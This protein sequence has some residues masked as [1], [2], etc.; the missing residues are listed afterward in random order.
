LLRTAVLAHLSG[1][2][3]DAVTGAT[4]GQAM[5]EQL[6]HANLFLVPLDGERG[7]YR[8]HHLFAEVLRQR[9]RQTE[10]ALVPE[11]HRRA[12]AWFAERGLDAEAIQHALAAE[13]WQRAAQL[14]EQ[15]T[16]APS[17]RSSFN[18]QLH[19]MR[20]WLEALPET[21]VRARPVLCIAHAIA[22]MFT[23][24]L[25]GAEARLLDAERG[26][27]PDTPSEEAR[28]LL[29]WVAMNRASIARFSGDLA[30]CVEYARQAL[31]SQPAGPVGIR[32]P[33]LVNAAHAYLVTGDVTAVTERE[34]AAVV[35]PARES[36]NIFAI[37]RGLTTLAR[38]QVLRGRL[39]QAEA[40]YAE[41]AQVAPGSGAM[42]ALV[43]APAY[44]IGL[45]DL[46][47][48]RNDLDAAEEHLAR[49][50]ALVSGALT[51]DAE[52]AT[53]GHIAL[54]RLLQARGEADRALA[55]LDAFAHLG[56]ERRFHAPLLARGAAARAR[57]DLARGDQAAALRWAEECGLHPTDAPD[58]PREFEHLT[59]ARVLIAAGHEGSAAHARDADG[60]LR[61]L[62]R[63]L[64]AAEACERLGSV[65]EICTLRAL[66][67]RT[68]GDRGAA[69]AHIERSLQLASPEG[70]VRVFADEGAPL[71]ELLGAWHADRR[72]SPAPGLRDY[73]AGL[74][75]AFAVPVRGSLTP[76]PRGD[77]A[78]LPEPLSERELAV[79]RLIAE[80]L[81]NGE[82]AAR[83]FVAIS[84][85]KWHI[86]AIFGKLA[87]TSRTQAVARARAL[88]LLGE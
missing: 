35:G 76:R 56:R 60:V 81:S 83:L 75:A 55:T 78:S 46:W 47:R 42:L 2:L 32:A 39:H 34:V 12:S 9:L 31:Q 18:G 65:I 88:H 69:L 52:Y 54:A 20:G 28:F 3:C 8:Y 85:V 23:N 82:I 21:L 13:D 70:Y 59:L 66:A 50:L 63:L 29:S 61:L 7:W 1:P 38:L 24:D 49:G 87:V 79:L 80:G 44:Y 26:V 43:G 74:L 25:D 4:D 17:S 19:T 58:F 27:G 10:P 48:E 14:L 45:G 64:A 16:I 68:L 53:L 6:E 22:L 33:A 77:A 67:L 40:T 30:R 57:L 36:G 11:L 15:L 37:L 41:A 71:A 51:V 72:R 73:A 84:T 62:D 5:L 86:N